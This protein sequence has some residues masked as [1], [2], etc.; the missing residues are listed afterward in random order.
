MMNLNY[1]MVLAVRYSRLFLVYNQYKPKCEI[2]YTFMLNKSY[3]C[4]LNVEPSNLVIL[5]NTE[6]DKIVITLSLILRAFSTH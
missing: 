4:L 1:Q 2:L 3:V 5:Y 6:F